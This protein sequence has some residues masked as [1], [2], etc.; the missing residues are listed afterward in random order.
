MIYTSFSLNGS[1]EMAYIEEK[2][3]ENIIPKLKWELI[4]N[5][6]PGYWEDM[7][8]SFQST[9][10][11]RKLK[12]NPE[13]GLQSYPIAGTA[14][15]MALPNILGTFFY[16]KS[17]ECNENNEECFIHFEG[18]QNC[19]KVWI[20]D[21]FLGCHEGY[22]TPF[23][24][25][26]PPKTLKNGDN[27]FV[28]CV[29]NHRL[30]GYAD[31]PISGLTS[32]AANEC[33][34]GI[35]GNVELRS[36]TC[37][38]RDVYLEIS[39]DLKSAQVNLEMTSNT[40]CV[41][42]VIDGNVILKEG[43]STESFSFETNGLELWSPENP[44]L[45]TLK[46]I[47]NGFSHETSFG[48]RN[49][50]A[51]AVHFKLNGTPYY[52]R[53]I[54]EHCYFPETI[55][56]NHDY[57]YYRSIVKAVKNLGF[58]FIRFHTYIPE[59]EYMCAA[60][61]LGMLV[62]VECPNN[63]TLEQWEEIVKFCRRHTSVV[64]YCCGNELHLNEEFIEYLSKFADIVHK[65]TNSLFS[66]MS[67]LRGVEYIFEKA[68]QNDVIK[69]PF[70]HNPVRFKRLNEFCDLYN[71]YTN[72]QN[73]Y[74]SIKCEPKL[75]DSWSSAYGKPRLSHEICIDGTY[76]NLELKDRYKNLRVGKTDMFSSIERHLTEKGLIDKAPLYFKNSSEWQRRVRKY[77][78][79]TTRMSE[80]L[81]G[82]DFLGPIDTHWHTF[83]YDVGMM[84]EFYELKP[85]ETVRN[86]LMYNSPTVLLNDLYRKTNF[87]SEEEVN[88]GLFVSH[89]GKE[90]LKNATLSI[91]LLKEN[92][93]IFNEFADIGFVKNGAVSAIH[94][95]K[96]KMP[97]VHKPVAVK[98]YV[99]LEEGKL[100]A[101]NEWEL[102][103][104]PEAKEIVTND[105]VI[106]EN[107]LK[108]Y[109][110][111]N[112]LSMGKTVVL[113]GREP[114]ANLPTTYQIALAG[115]TSG[116]LA[117]V[118]A[119]HP[120][121]NDIPNDGF[122]GWQFAELL[123][124]G[125]AV[126]FN[127][128]NLPFDPIIEVVSTHKFVIKQSALFE[129]NVLG[130]KLIVCSFSFK[131]TDPCANWLKANIIKYANSDLF[132]PKHTLSEEQLDTL[133]DKNFKKAVKNENMAFNP[134][135]KTAIKM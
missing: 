68:C 47:C 76:T 110:L 4:N 11:F 3:S 20:N 129:F 97:K 15:D 118:V 49:L 130:G 45:Y 1:W 70:E 63:T 46:I 58:N 128:E 73:S 126:C 54:C 8:A 79:E 83:G 12:I 34:G 116:N 109:E 10:F 127:N 108:S 41:W 119:D 88:I 121:T 75:V 29:S 23:D 39:K 96:F 132:E 93:V 59:E 102:Y 77:G 98:L 117:T 105:N 66:P 99:T 60:D 22:S 19:V 94:N 115:R 72:A 107:S 56:P 100:F 37:P 61:E 32:R 62:Q 64:I 122:C 44:K 114:F 92:K 55:H 95:C 51:E 40:E 113:L 133:M 27:T 52:L 111:K 25:L 65:N 35:T 36:Y 125:A 85:G 90:D 24:I 17:I 48:V 42:Q 7:N 80:N 67:A 120:I 134:N 30:K 16:K 57:K 74:D 81:S 21:I 69:E 91:R 71:S 38:L 112:Y 131:E 124:D 78:F 14:P 50:V 135:D 123:E 89:Y 2:Y 18:V 84:N 103:I 6:V 28:L 13:Y 33:T 106:I 43:K 9:D 26:V 82:Y 87:Y 5:S 53:G 104:F 101:E 86:V 31:R